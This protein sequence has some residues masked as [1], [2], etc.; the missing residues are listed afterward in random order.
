MSLLT[1]VERE[2]ATVLHSHTWTGHKYKDGKKL[3]NVTV[4]LQYDTTLLALYIFF[5]TISIERLNKLWIGQR[6]NRYIW[7]KT[8]HLNSELLVLQLSNKIVYWLRKKDNR[9]SFI[10]SCGV[11]AVTETW[12]LRTSSLMRRTTSASL[13]LAWPPYRWETACWRPAVG[14][15]LCSGAAS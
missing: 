4:Y 9:I 5:L 7:L 10:E 1:V 8:E 12:S 11:C 13:T 2:G 3:K 15:Y 14:E 6:N